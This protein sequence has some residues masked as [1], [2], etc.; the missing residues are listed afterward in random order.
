MTPLAVSG[1]W[2][3]FAH[4]KSMVAAP[5]VCMALNEV[6]N[7]AFRASS[8]AIEFR[9][10]DQKWSLPAH[11]DGTI[12]VK[13]GDWTTSLGIIFNTDSMV[14]AIV[15]REVLLAMFA[16]MD[17]SSVMSITVGNSKPRSVS[18]IGSSK[19]TNAFR[20]CVG[21]HSNDKKAGENPFN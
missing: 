3:A 12:L 4:R 5:D 6:Q 21:L 20:T 1:D 7:V 18:L 19:A 14:S 13:V 16:G 17:K 10:S 2:V 11:I 9:V 8:E 15:D